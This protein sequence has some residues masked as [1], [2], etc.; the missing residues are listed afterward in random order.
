[1]DPTARGG[2]GLL[3]RAEDRVPRRRG[4]GDRRRVR[5]DTRGGRAPHSAGPAPVHGLTPAGAA[6]RRAAEAP[7]RDG[8]GPEGNTRVAYPPPAPGMPRTCPL[9]TLVE[10]GP[11]HGSRPRNG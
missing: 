10:G 9:G 8:R 11:I 6:R 2:A 3:R 1:M 4:G 7:R 5:G